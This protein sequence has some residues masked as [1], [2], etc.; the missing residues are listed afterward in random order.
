MDTKSQ[1][2]PT[3]ITEL[4]RI[5]AL[6]GDDIPKIRTRFGAVPIGGRESSDGVH[7]VEL[8]AF[9]CGSLAVRA[10]DEDGNREW[11]S[12]LSEFRLPA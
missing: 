7:Y 6:R 11:H 5:V 2:Q 4:N 8:F 3:N 12:D 1:T 10:V 9:P